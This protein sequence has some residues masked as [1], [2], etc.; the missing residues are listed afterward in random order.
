M[1][2]AVV[3]GVSRSQILVHSSTRP[4]IQVR[5]PEMK[6]SLFGS[7]EGD[8]LVT[9]SPLS[10]IILED[11]SL[12]LSPISVSAVYPNVKVNLTQRAPL[13]GT[14]LLLGFME[15]ARLGQTAKQLGQSLA[16][17]NRFYLWKVLSESRSKVILNPL[18]SAKGSYLA[19][20]QTLRLDVSYNMLTYLRLCLAEFNREEYADL[21]QKARSEHDRSV[22]LVDV[23]H[24]VRQRWSEW[25]SDP[26]GADIVHLPLLHALYRKSDETA[27]GFGSAFTASIHWQNITIQETTSSI[28]RN[29][30]TIL[31]ARV[32]VASEKQ[33]MLAFSESK[34]SIGATP[35]ALHVTSGIHVE[36]LILHVFPTIMPFFEEAFR[37][38]RLL[39]KNSF[40]V[41]HV[42]STE[43]NS[44]QRHLVVEIIM[45]AERIRLRASAQNL[46]LDAGT[47]SPRLYI[48]MT[49]QPKGRPDVFAPAS[50]QLASNVRL[51]AGEFFLRARSADKAFQSDDSDILA[52][53]VASICKA[54][55]SFQSIDGQGPNVSFLVGCGPVLC[56][57]PRSATRTYQ[58]V[59]EWRANYLP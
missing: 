35:L 22:L 42:S 4:T 53:V 1:C 39:A 6:V 46:L 29:M 9:A 17:R 10:T 33:L 36:S 56:T 24:L 2:S 49:H 44:H 12:N 41:S 11:S 45:S 38:G 5:V 20:S 58:F 19:D 51:T 13:Y 59:D 28:M 34:P 32:A 26:D 8:R 47:S 50:P 16:T 7:E 21:L 25:T 18:S 31:G 52:S 43:Q 15:L 14:L 23:E 55:A 30:L 3:L 57:V 37:A 54:S 40:A 27:F 48:S